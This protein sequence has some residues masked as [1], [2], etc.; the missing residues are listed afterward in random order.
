VYS[1][2]VCGGSYG[3]VSYADPYLYV[4]CRDGLIAVRLAEPGASP[5]FSVAWSAPVGFANPPIVVGAS[6]W[7]IGRADGSLYALNAQ[8]GSGQFQSGAAPQAPPHFVT[9]GLGDGRILAVWGR[10]IAAFG[11]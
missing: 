7:G 8:D 11:P 9:P 4:P 6:V 10:A 5:G 1:S 2:Q 3:G